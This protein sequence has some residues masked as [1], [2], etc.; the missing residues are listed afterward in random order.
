M[1]HEG[2]VECGDLAIVPYKR[3]T[4]G[5]NDPS[6]VEDGIADCN[7][8]V[9]ELVVSSPEDGPDAVPAN[10]TKGTKGIK[11]RLHSDIVLKEFRVTGKGEYAAYLQAGFTEIPSQQGIEQGKGR[12]TESKE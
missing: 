5:Q 6:C 2:A 1:S 9:W 4:A 7:G 11:V 8:S 10:I 3:R 12:E